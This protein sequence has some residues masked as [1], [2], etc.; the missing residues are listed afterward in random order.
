VLFVPN[1]FD[2]VDL[3]KISKTVES[4]KKDRATLRRPVKLQGDWLFDPAKG[5]QFRTS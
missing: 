2:N 3:D 1:I 5:Y 4:G